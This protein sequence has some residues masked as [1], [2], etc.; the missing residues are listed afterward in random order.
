M[1]RPATESVDVL[2]NSPAFT[3][4]V[5]VASVPAV[6]CPGG[7]SIVAY[8]LKSAKKEVNREERVRKGV[9]DG[10]SGGQ[11]MGGWRRVFDNED[12]LGVPPYTVT[13]LAPCGTS[14]ASIN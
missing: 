13:R 12:D 11:C 8:S 6:S 9:P 10:R 1:T 4:P 2:T 5:A 3:G 14:V 7:L